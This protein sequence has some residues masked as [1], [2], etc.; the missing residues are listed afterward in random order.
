MNASRKKPN[1]TA[2][3]AVLIVVI[4]AI[5]IATLFYNAIKGKREYEEQNAPA[6]QSPNAASQG[7][8][9]AAQAAGASQ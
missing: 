4:V 5:V 2:R 3:V 6:S 9:T 1:P 8:N 7:A